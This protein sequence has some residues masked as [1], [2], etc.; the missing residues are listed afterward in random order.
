MRERGG[1]RVRAKENLEESGEG[2]WRAC[3]KKREGKHRMATHG[4]AWHGCELRLSPPPAPPPYPCVIHP[5]PSDALRGLA[6][7]TVHC[8]GAKHEQWLSGH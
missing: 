3:T 2:G 8:E 5:D 4:L 1:K 7:C 6:P